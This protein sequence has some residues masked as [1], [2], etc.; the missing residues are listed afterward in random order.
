M[1]ILAP[2]ERPPS[3]RT[4][5]EVDVGEAEWL[6]ISELVVLITDDGIWEELKAA[7][8]DATEEVGPTG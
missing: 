8:T 7:D 4:G 6:E 3:G 2:V 5:D 1:P